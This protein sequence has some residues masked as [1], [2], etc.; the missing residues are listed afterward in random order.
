M[1]E[2]MKSFYDK[3][4]KSKVIKPDFDVTTTYT[5]AFVDKGVGLDLK[6]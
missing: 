2:R 4:V 3:M 1:P 5:T 6:K